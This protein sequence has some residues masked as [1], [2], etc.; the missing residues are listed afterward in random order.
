MQVAASISANLSSLEYSVDDKW[1][2]LISNRWSW[3]LTDHGT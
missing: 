2:E 3:I 1:P